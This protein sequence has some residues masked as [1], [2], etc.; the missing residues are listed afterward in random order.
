MGYT[1]IDA[2]SPFPVR[3]RNGAE[4]NAVWRD[5]ARQVCV[6]QASLYDCNSIFGID[7]ENLAHSRELN[8]NPT[9]RGERAS[10][11]ARAR[12]A[13]REAH[14]FVRQKLQDF[15]RLFS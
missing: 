4:L 12:A 8:Y 6:H 14:V 13:R 9:A 11:K 10:G 1:K 3:G 2:M 5:G 15:R 7:A